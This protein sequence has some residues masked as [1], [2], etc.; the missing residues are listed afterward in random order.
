MNRSSKSIAALLLFSSAL[1]IFC[2][3]S[4]SH[5]ATYYVRPDGGTSTQCT[6]LA[7]APYPGF[8][9][10][11]DCSWAHPF[12]ALDG[13]DPPC[14]LLAGG[15]ALIIHTGNYKIGFG[16]PNSAWCSK[17][18]PWDC[19]LPP[20]PSGP[21]S[22]HPTSILG[23]DWARGCLNPPELWGTE[24]VSEIINLEGTSNALIACLELTDHSG[25][26]ESHG[27]P[28]V[29]CQRGSYPFGDWSPRGI[30][31]V[32][33][34][35]VMLKDL[36]IH[37][38]A[39]AGIQ[40]GR[41]A[42][43][44]MDHVRIAGNGWVGWEG[45]LGQESSNS[46]TLTF[47]RWLVE[48]NGCAETF[49]D[50]KPAHCW[51]Q[52]AGGYGD[53]VGTAN[54]GG[55]WIIEDSTF[56]YNTSDGLDLLYVRE[57][58]SSITIRRSK[59]YGNA[60]NQ[61]KTT[62]SA[63]VENCLLIAN[64]GYFDGKPFAPPIDG[65]A[66]IDHCRA[67]G[68]AVSLTLFKG[69]T[70]SVV[71]STIVGQGDCLAGVECDWERSS[72][73]GS[74]QIIVQ[75]NVFRGYEDFNQTGDQ[76][77]YFWID[78]ENLYDVNWDYNIIHQAKIADSLPPLGVHDTF[79]DPL[80]FNVD[81]A[82]FDGRLLL[83]SS[84]IDSGITVG[85]LGGLIPDHDLRQRARPRGS[86]VDRGAYEYHRAL[87]PDFDG[88]QQADLTVWR[89][90]RGYWYGWDLTTNNKLLKNWGAQGDWPFSGDFD[91][92]QMA[93]LGVW[94]PGNGSFYLLLSSRQYSFSGARKIVWGADG[95][96]PVPGDYDG[97]AKTDFGVW[98]PST[99]I[100]FIQDGDGKELARVCWGVKDDVPVPGDYDGDGAAD[101]GTWR[102]STGTWFIRGVAKGFTIQSQWGCSTDVPVPAD[103][104][105]DGRTDLA[106]WRP[107]TGMW[108][109]RDIA[110]KILVA[111]KYGTNGDI[112]LAADC[113]GDGKA[114]LIIFRP[115]T[116]EWFIKTAVTGFF[117]DFIVKWGSHGDIP[118]GH[119]PFSGL[120]KYLDR[121]GHW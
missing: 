74:E 114:D 117:K 53:G 115:A 110:G 63:K 85:G 59:A 72:C 103:Y 65:Q 42:D 99:G 7:D 116:G 28:L 102:P 48:W 43:W 36:N 120:Q 109:V 30:F 97:D 83:G 95:D 87:G 118:I 94:R 19:H 5:A 92:D 96:I 89:P 84:G 70:V 9:A 64:C 26:V 2:P 101:L 17:F 62:G 23:T 6:G 20:L 54:T 47:R 1:F 66:S 10:A 105:G 86:G 113:D 3:Q 78:P 39:S 79:A 75:N 45:D 73:D 82:Q 68:A 107:S 13:N 37:G 98:R 67:G 57:E 18:W 93:D 4:V 38:F 24:R 29:S 14:W 88:N 111:A 16:A 80:F 91:G 15:D 58:G 81:L 8:G 11:Q 52:P 35:N 46:G 60:G 34:N 51:A 121:L 33:S 61:L 56:R 77:C 106:V 40:A 119:S 41:I 71:N 100:W 32:D 76:A 69:N 104:E 108:H 112:P 22:K 31:A 50:Q 44:Q 25:C 55:N 90:S 21:D 49:P 27:N 12:Y